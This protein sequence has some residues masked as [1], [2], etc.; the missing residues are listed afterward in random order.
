[1]LVVYIH[2]FGHRKTP[3]MKSDVLRYNQKYDHTHGHIAAGN[4]QCINLDF[5]VQLAQRISKN[6]IKS[7]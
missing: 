1:M 6:A 5:V 3:I 4:T 2:G 7:H